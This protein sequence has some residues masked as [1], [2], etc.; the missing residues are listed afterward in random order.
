MLP[1]A[2]DL[3]HG[4]PLS[5]TGACNVVPARGDLGVADARIIAPGEDT[6]SVL[7]TR[8]SVRDANAM[9]PIASNVVDFYDQSTPRA[10]L[11]SFVRAMERERYDVVLRMVPNADR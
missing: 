8:M 3:R 4:T 1:V 6:R 9:P 11:R 10:A 2:L 5:Q 7:L